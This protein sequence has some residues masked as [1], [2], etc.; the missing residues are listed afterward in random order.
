M[1]QKSYI[2]DAHNMTFIPF[3]VIRK[4]SAPAEPVKP[5]WISH[6][7]LVYVKE[8]TGEA[9]VNGVKYRIAPG[10]LFLLQPGYIVEAHFHPHHPASWY[11]LRFAFHAP[12]PAGKPGEPDEDARSPLSSDVEIHAANMPRIAFLFEK[13]YQ[14]KRGTDFLKRWKTHLLFQELVYTIVSGV[15]EA[16]QEANHGAIKRILTYMHAHYMEP[17]SMKALA[18]MHGV[19]PTNFAGLFKKHTG[20][21]P[22]Q[23]LTRLRVEQ[24]KPWLLARERLGEVARRVGY[25]DE[26]YFSRIFKK[27][28]GVTPT[29]YAK[30]HVSEHVLTLSPI[31]NDYLAA[32]DVKPLATLYREGLDLVGGMLPYIRDNL[33]GARVIES[34]DPEHLRAVLEEPPRLILGE[35]LGSQSLLDALP[36]IAP[37]VLLSIRRDWRSLL[38]EIANLLERRDRF[39]EWMRQF[40]R[41][42]AMARQQLARKLGNRATVMV[43]VAGRGEFRI[44]G[45]RRQLGEILYQE[46][47]LS[48]PQGIRVHDHYR[49]ISLHDI[50]GLKPDFI[51]LTTLNSG[52]CMEQI[53]LL[54]ESKIWQSMDCVRN[55]RVFEVEC[56][57]NHHAPV[58]H[59]IAIDKALHYLLR[60]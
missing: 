22:I 48:P 24:A 35:K 27:V 29:V 60:A 51:F 5:L 42:A 54:K 9:T 10:Q 41:K 23:Y 18:K 2:H 47:A 52:S 38:F 39:L 14:L 21:T 59:S 34:L 55:G 43:L 1:I 53:R 11:A 58:K 4:T 49:R 40:K 8:G 16:E 45:G 37:T 12:A 6:C 15:H 13:M 3:P 28:A 32:L 57:L 33:E 17:I 30:Q 31:L 26:L 44:Y 50:A 46:L 25:R 20:I 56:W 19:S 36:P 7:Y